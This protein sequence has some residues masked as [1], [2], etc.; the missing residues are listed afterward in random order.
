MIRPSF[1]IHDM[2]SMSVVLFLLMFFGSERGFDKN[3][4]R[5]PVK[6]LQGEVTGEN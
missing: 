4:N 1:V 3:I 5:A 2:Y 6:K